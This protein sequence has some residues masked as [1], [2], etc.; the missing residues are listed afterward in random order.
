MLISVFPFLRVGSCSS[1]YIF[2]SFKVNVD[3]TV[4]AIGF[5]SRI[6]PFV[7][8]ISIIKV[9]EETGEP[10]RN[11]SG[12]CIPC[13]PDEPG[14]FIGKIKP[15]NP[16]RAFLGYVDKEASKKKIVCDVF[17]KGDSAFLSGKCCTS[18]S[19]GLSLIFLV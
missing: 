3:N 8:P 2:F 14:V 5:V 13:K 15:N 12:L 11:K 7:Y 4:G 9:N 16:S 19:R 6:L 1:K 10:I 18:F 17:S